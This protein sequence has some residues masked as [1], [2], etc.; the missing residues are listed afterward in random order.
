VRAGPTIGAS[1]LRPQFV[2]VNAAAPRTT[3]RSAP[4]QPLLDLSMHRIVIAQDLLF[5]N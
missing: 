4:S 5:N 2:A 3:R 1:A